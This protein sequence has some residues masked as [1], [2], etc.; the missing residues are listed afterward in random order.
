[1]SVTRISTQRR[2]RTSN[3]G[4]FSPARIA[5]LFC[6]MDASDESTIVQNGTNVAEW[7]SKAGNLTASQTTASLQPAYTTAGQNNLNC[8][9]FDGTGRRMTFNQGGV[10]SAWS[11]MHDGT[12]QYGVYWVGSAIAGN[13]NTYLSN[14][15]NFGTNDGNGFG[16]NHDFGVLYGNPTIRAFVRSATG[17]IAQVDTNLASNTVRAMELLADLSNSTAGNRL[18]LRINGGTQQTSTAGAGTISTGNPQG[19]FSVGSSGTGTLFALNG[20]ICE[21]IIYKGALADSETAAIR[22]YLIGKWGL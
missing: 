13:M 3:V 9:T 7:R 8:V 14:T 19:P 1:M 2:A 21:I 5:N 12:T 6:W 11:F 20:R 4:A 17:V 15:R 16:I 22:S 18:R 10:S